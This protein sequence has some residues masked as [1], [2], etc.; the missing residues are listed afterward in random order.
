MS[1]HYKFGIEPIDIIESWDLSFTEG[2]IVK[3]LLRS[4]YKGDELGDLKKALY[5]LKRKIKEVKVKDD[6]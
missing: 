2:N 3:Y 1:D 4:P 5:Y 6:N